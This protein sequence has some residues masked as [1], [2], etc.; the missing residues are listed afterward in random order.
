MALRFS[1]QVRHR[2]GFDG[3][4]MQVSGCRGTGGH[5]PTTCENGHYL[6]QPP[7]DQIGGQPHYVLQTQSLSA[8]AGK[9]R[10][11][12]FNTNTRKW[13][14]SPVC[15]D[16]EGEFA[17]SETA[18][19]AARWCHRGPPV[20]EPGDFTW[21]TERAVAVIHRVAA[22]D[23]GADAEEADGHF[24]LA[25]W[26]DSNHE[27]CVFSQSVDRAFFLSLDP[28][29]L[30]QGIHP[31][32]LDHLERNGVCIGEGLEALNLRHFEV[33]SALTGVR[34]SRE[35]AS[36]LL[37]GAFCLTGDSL[38]KMA[39]IY[40]RLRCG[41]PVVLMGECGCGK[42]MLIK[43]LCAWLGVRLFVLDVNG[44]TSADEIVGTLESAEAALRDGEERVLVFF[45][46]LN[47]CGHV[48]LMVEVCTLGSVRGRRLPAAISLLAA[49]N[50]Y[51]RRPPQQAVEGSGL[52]FSLP[53]AEVTDDPLAEL[54]YRVHRVPGALQ[55]FVFD[56][57][58]LADADEEKYVK[59]ILAR[60]LQALRKRGYELTLP[61]DAQC[62]LSLLVT[63]Q[64][65]LRIAEG[66]ASAVSLRDV[67]RCC[68]LLRWFC[69][70]LVPKQ[71]KAKQKVSPVAAA[72]VLALAFVYYFRLGSAAARAAYWEALLGAL[73]YQRL[74]RPAKFD[75]AGFG[76]L[77]QAGAFARVL[78]GVQRRFSQHVQVDDGIALNESLTTNLFVGLVCILNKLP[79]F[80]VG[81]P[82]TSKT[83][84]LQARRAPRLAAPRPPPTPPR[85]PRR[86]SRPTCK[87]PSLRA[88][89][90]APSPRCTSSPF[91][92]RQ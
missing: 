5:T 89:S 30:A 33:L 90:S 43:Y 64:R 52:V 4:A 67:R 46:E 49:I 20:A 57:G 10:H 92:A 69:E 75:T 2:D 71:G 36:A 85:L 74:G 48:S 63:S 27:V 60:E 62:A 40:V 61:I 77:V 11:L 56:F 68:D 13:Q 65:H 22:A 59:A 18:I 78:V 87:A 51:R 3:V 84:T 25:S 70:H 35:E 14:I 9:R 28:K 38:L 37:G 31:H 42:T 58:R 44:G 91:S 8:R 26:N 1:L 24:E 66:D 86:C 47:T 73:Q 72:M 88:P 12:F 23:V 39:A 15:N 83:L 55:Q 17:V 79:L 54:V 80:I 7:L 34:R 32:L 19:C 16:S 82:G 45:D 50:P 76:G 29:R 41:V 53:G 21:T 81:K 6:L